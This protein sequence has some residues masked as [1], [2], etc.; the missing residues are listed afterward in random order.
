MKTPKGLKAAPQN[1]P[2]SKLGTGMG[3][4]SV[5]LGGKRGI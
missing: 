3:A 2:T 4:A 1:K 5:K